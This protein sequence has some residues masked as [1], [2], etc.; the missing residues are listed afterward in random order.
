MLLEIALGVAIFT[1]IILALVVIIQFAKDIL[2]P[3]GTV[4][5][6][7][8]NERELEAPVGGK[9]LQTLAGAGLYVPSACGGG[10]SCAQCR[11]KVFEGGGNIL[12]TELNH[13]TKREAKECD[14]LSCQVAVKQNMK[15]EIPEEVFGVKKWECTVRSNHN[16]ATFIKELVLE[17]PAGE[18][19]NFRAGGYIQIECPP[20]VV[21]YKDFDVEPKFREDW[22]KFNLWQYTSKVDEPVER[23]YSMANY[24]EELGIIM[25]NVRIASPPP[26]LPNVPAGKMSSYI[27]NLKPGDK[28][29]ISGPFGEFFARDTDKEMVFIG[30]GAGMAPM[31]SHIFDQLT[32]IKTQRKI[33]FWYGARSK[34]EMFYVEDFDKLAADNPNFEWHV[35]LSEPQ[36]DDN[37]TGYTGFIHNVLYENYLK[38]HKAPEDCEYYMCGPPVMNAAVIKML[39]DLGVERKD[40]MLDDFGG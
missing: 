27:F 21:N 20:H 37:W 14:R 3:A 28:V 16:V 24:P 39:L 38:N 11:V 2:V 35:A 1:G 7:I 9:L 26:K 22:D 31:R 19:V 4:K 36:P 15:I 25:L 29:T 30:G 23:A 8:N 13:I 40:I 34:R 10:G 5:I 32:R 33:S 12:P 18:R 6:L 17:L